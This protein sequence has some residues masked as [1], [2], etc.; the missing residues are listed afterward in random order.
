M[1]HLYFFCL[2]LHFFPALIG[3][4]C[5]RRDASGYAKKEIDQTHRKSKDRDKNDEPSPCF[6]VAPQN[7][8]QK[9]RKAK[10]GLESA[11]GAKRRNR[12]PHNRLTR[13]EVHALACRLTSAGDHSHCPCSCRD[14]TNSNSPDVSQTCQQLM[15]EGIYNSSEL[16]GDRWYLGQKNGQ[17]EKQDRWAKRT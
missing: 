12:V 4:S 8:Q 16:I 2:L 1:L 15:Q 14:V 13:V 17:T 3:K 9:K 5:T 10:Q 6:F 7:P 11:P